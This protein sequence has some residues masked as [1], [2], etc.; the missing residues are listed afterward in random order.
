M[1]RTERLSLIQIGLGLATIA[2]LLLGSSCAT[3]QPRFVSVWIKLP[4]DYKPPAPL[5]DC[6]YVSGTSTWNCY[7]Q[8]KGN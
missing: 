8:T 6:L 4:P 7:L 2:V 1:N 3:T 5:Q